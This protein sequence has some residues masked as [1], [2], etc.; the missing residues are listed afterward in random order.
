MEAKPVPDLSELTEVDRLI[1]EP[2]RM[3]IMAVLYG[4][5]SAD[6]KFLLNMTGLT[7]GNLSAHASKLEEAGYVAI[8]KQFRGK[9][10]YTEYRLT[11]QGRAAFKAYR[12]KLKWM[13]RVLGS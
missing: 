2:A 9:V 6:F 12:A 4:V 11:K 8:D 3:A 5:E 10:P 13:V 7:K 1:H